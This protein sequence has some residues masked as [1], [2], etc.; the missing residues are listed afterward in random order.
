VLPTT[1]VTAYTVA[2]VVDSLF[3]VL[4]DHPGLGVAAVACV[5]LVLLWRRVCVTRGTRDLAFASVVE[6]EGV[7]ESRTLPATCCVATGAGGA[8]LAKMFLRLGMARDACGGC[9]LIDVVS[10]AL[11]TDRLGVGTGERERCL[12]MVE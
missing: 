2:N 6:R 7:F 12:A 5:G 9:A 11:A 3:T 4:R 10:V 8:K 1:G